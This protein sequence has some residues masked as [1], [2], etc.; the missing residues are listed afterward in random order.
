MSKWSS[1]CLN[2]LTKLYLIP[3]YKN[4]REGPELGRKQWHA[5]I[6][7]L[8]IIRDLIKSEKKNHTHLSKC[9]ESIMYNRL[10]FEKWYFPQERCFF[11]FF[12]LIFYMSKTNFKKSRIRDIITNLQ[13][14]LI[15][16][17]LQKRFRCPELGE[18]KTI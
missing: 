10:N 5:E 6:E 14:H 4:I 7:F 1:N 13:S 17:F 8:K 12:F 18:N 3:V 2:N 16:Y 15:I 9:L 11:F